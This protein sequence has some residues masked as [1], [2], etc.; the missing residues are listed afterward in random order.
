MDA[1]WR[2]DDGLKVAI[3]GKGTAG[4]MTAA[5]CKRWINADEIEWYFDPSIKP[6]AVGEGSTLNLPNRLNDS[7]NF[8]P[9][10][11]D[12]VGATVKTGIY[13]EG[14]GSKRK[15]LSMTSRALQRLCHFDATLLQ[16]FVYDKLK[17][18]VSIKEANVSSDD[19]DADYIIDCSGRPSSF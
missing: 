10:H 4:C 18:S 14:W 8:S 15:P 5:H 6:Q 9:R 11:F 7:L 2:G 3:I 17:D 12:S 16:G 13:K 1:P 19:I